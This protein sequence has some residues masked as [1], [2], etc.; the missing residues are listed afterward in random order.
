MFFIFF[1][2]II[3]NQPEE[4]ESSFNLIQHLELCRGCHCRDCFHKYLDKQENHEPPRKDG[5]QRPGSGVPNSEGK[6]II[7]SPRGASQIRR[8]NNWFDNI[9]K[10]RNEHF[11]DCHADGTKL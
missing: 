3:T 5:R 6:G 9:V 11:W 7:P 2:Q 1:S 10:F 4:S 8:S